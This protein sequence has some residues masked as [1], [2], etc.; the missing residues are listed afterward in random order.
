MHVEVRGSVD[1]KTQATSPASRSREVRG[2]LQ[3]LTSPMARLA[4]RPV[5]SDALAPSAL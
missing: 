5:D 4:R 1:K 2:L 3:W